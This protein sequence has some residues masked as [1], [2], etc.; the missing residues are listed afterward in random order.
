MN[1]IHTHDVIE[2][3]PGVWIDS[4]FPVVCDED[5]PPPDYACRVGALLA[6]RDPVFLTAITGLAP[7]IPLLCACPGGMDCPA[8]LIRQALLHRDMWWP[9]FHKTRTYAVVG[10]EP[11]PP[12]I[13]ERLVQTGRLLA[14]HHYTV[15][16]SRRGG[17]D[18]ACILGAQGVVARVP[19]K[20]LPEALA[21]ARTLD[22]FFSS[23]S[24][25]DWVIRARIVHQI[26]GVD[27]RH[28]VDFVVSWSLTD[29]EATP[30]L[31]GAGDLSS[32][33]RIL[34]YRWSIPTV[35]LTSYDFPKSLSV[36]LSQA[37]LSSR[38]EESC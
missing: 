31:F 32:L 10:P 17:I 8:T 21:I 5:F 14:S 7:N 28:P 27:L 11:A 18:A 6:D 30:P 4:R 2:S 20:P 15:I 3:P 25:G 16:S 24:P 13:S 34:A 35:L 36:W 33:A 19:T 38:E 12:D 29:H 26:L 22:P 9:D 23:E 37:A 1:V